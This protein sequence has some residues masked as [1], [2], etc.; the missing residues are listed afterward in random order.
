MLRVGTGQD[1]HGLS[2]DGQ[3]VLAGVSLAGPGF[4]THSDGDVVAHAIVDSLAGALA[5]GTLGDFFPE[6]DPS[7]QDAASI[8]FLRR[9]LPVLERRGARVVNIDVTVEIRSPILTP[10]LAEMR[11]NV[12]SRLGIEVGQVS[13]KPKSNDGFGDTG[14]GRAA[15]AIVVCLVDVGEIDSTTPS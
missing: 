13:I 4:N 9:F 14:T 11:Q 12:A 2:P 8:D 1:I 5:A 7:D 3:L 10:Y 15:R 6:N